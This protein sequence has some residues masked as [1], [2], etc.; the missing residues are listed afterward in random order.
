MPSAI[1]IE[2]LA[3]KFMVPMPPPQQGRMARLK[4]FMQRPT[5]E[6]WAVRD[7]SF[8]VE[9]GDIVGFLGTNGSGKST[10]VKM[11]C[12]ILTPTSGSIDVLG[13]H[14]S[15]QRSTYV[16]HIGLVLGQRSLLWWNIPVIESLKLYRDIYGISAAAFQERLNQITRRFDFE[17]LLHVPVRKLSL[18]QRMRAE[19]VASLLHRPKIIFLDEPTIG[20]DIL[21][22]R[23][24]KDFIRE[25]NQQEGVT[26]VFTSHNMLD[27]EDLCE[28]CLIV[29]RG[30]CVY[31]G[32]IERLRKR[33]QIKQL[34]FE[35]DQILDVERF[36]RILGDCQVLGRSETS[37]S[38]QVSSD[39][40][41][42]VVQS[43]MSAAHVLNLNVVP[44]TLE[45]VVGRFFAT[46]QE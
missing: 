45:A 9:Q 7:L 37:L 21:S 3:K 35:F 30:T 38:V 34:D 10:T 19:I 23:Q 36:E 40:S 44:P 16:H 2:G 5:E 42:A 13:F 43:L 4:Y 14:P 15:R 39:Q 24:F 27:V 25:V 46:A 1:R 17:S 26:I 29:D 22:R 31:D 18:G 12:G 32:T 6:R 33:D 41:M 20:L 28:R 11:L 8:A